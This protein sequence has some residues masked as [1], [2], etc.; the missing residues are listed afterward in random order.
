MVCYGINFKFYYYRLFKTETVV[1]NARR[2]SVYRHDRDSHGE[3]LSHSRIGGE[4][5][6]R[7]RQHGQRHPGV[8]REHPP[9]QGV[10]PA[11]QD[12]LRQRPR[13]LHPAARRHRLPI[14]RGIPQ[15]VL[16][17]LGSG[18][19]LQERQD[20]YKGGDEVRHHLFI[21]TYI[22]TNIHT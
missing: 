5:Q 1:G 11:P 8:R 9:C 20:L 4:V 7:Q 15:K 17:L 13:L 10:A 18:Q 2:I 12:K 22:H 14:P 19:H 6:E 21:S 3:L 16:H